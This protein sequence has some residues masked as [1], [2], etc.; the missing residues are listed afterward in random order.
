MENTLPRVYKI[1]EELRAT[2]S[3]PSFYDD[4]LKDRLAIAFT[5]IPRQP[6]QK[7]PRSRQAIHRRCNRKA[8]QK[9]YLNALDYNIHIFIA[10]ILA[11]SVKKCLSIGTALYQIRKI[12]EPLPF[13]QQ[14]K[15]KLEA[16]AIEGTYQKNKQYRALIESLF[17]SNA[18]EA[19][20]TTDAADDEACWVYN[21]ACLA[22]TRT[23]FGDEIGD[24]VAGAPLR[25]KE[26]R[27]SGTFELTEFVKTNF[28]KRVFQDAIISLQVGDA[29]NIARTFFPSVSD[30]LFSTLFAEEQGHDN[31]ANMSQTL[32][33]KHGI[34]CAY[35]TF[36]GAST[37]AIATSFSSS[38][39]NAIEESQLRVW[40]KGHLL[41][42]T[43]DCLLLE[44][45]RQPPN[46]GT[47]RIRIGFKLGT[48]IVNALYAY[49]DD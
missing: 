39:F 17:P 7:S 8:A 47:L 22:A 28:P 3:I 10:F 20:P 26:K 12:E 34:D 40:E 13:Q 21:A 36:R 31:Q 16:L 6:R 15:I 32:S 30:D 23:L 24:G 46:L 43:T 9:V 44:V 29:R 14:T 27:K 25:M 49:S 18:E 37:A 5:P 19:K 2:S 33:I 11:V 42:D 4:V 48:D 1:Q 38:L 35:F 41:L 45:S